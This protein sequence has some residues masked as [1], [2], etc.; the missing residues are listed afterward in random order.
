VLHTGGAAALAVVL[1]WALC[2]SR[3]EQPAGARLSRANPAVPSGAPLRGAEVP[4]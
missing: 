4:R 1:V 2:E 3:R